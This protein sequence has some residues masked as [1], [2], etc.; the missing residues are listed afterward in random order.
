MNGPRGAGPGRVAFWGNFG[1]LN[2]GNECTLA[3]AIANV[4]AQ[5]PQAQLLCVCCEP[6]DA[7]ARHGIPAVAMATPPDAPAGGGR[8]SRIARRLR[9]ELHDWR[10]ALR[11]AADIDAL[12]VTGTGILTDTGEGALGLPYQLFKWCLCTRLRGGR[13]LFVSVGAEAIRQPLTRFLLNR[14][15]RLAA[16][17]SYRDGHS[18]AR[19]RASGIPTDGDA[20]M[21]DLAF[22][23]PP[24]AAAPPRAAPAPVAVGLFNYRGRGQGGPLDAAAYQGYLEVI[25]ALI[26]T[27]LAQGHAVRVVIGDLAYDAAVLEDVRARLAAR[28]LDPGRAALEDAPAMSWEQLLTQLEGVDFVIASRFHNVLLAL[29]LGKPVVSVSYEAKNDALMQQMGLGRFCQT[30]DAPDLQ[31]LLVQFRELQQEAAALRAALAQRTAANR[32]QL[33][34]QYQAIAALLSAR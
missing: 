33:A 1:T 30:L 13:V 6:G 31:R 14:A 9:R 32:A 8:L 5:L 23:L 25:T 29:L 3:A 21:P 12:L 26:A 2:L 11:V 16:Y 28:G 7:A 15:L 34:Q 10:A 20:V 18:V 4:R 19:L 24:Q 17:R 22:S 27:L